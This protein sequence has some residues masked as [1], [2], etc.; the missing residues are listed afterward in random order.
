MSGGA[1]GSARLLAVQ[2][3]PGGGGICGLFLRRAQARRH[4]IHDV[5][6]E[7]SQSSRALTNVLK[8]LWAFSE[9]KNVLLRS[10][11][12]RRHTT[13]TPPPRFLRLW[14]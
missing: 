13:P 9:L 12:P 4:G 11:R 7:L 3:V 6:E 10:Q 5:R 1:R 2:A 14:R 8:R